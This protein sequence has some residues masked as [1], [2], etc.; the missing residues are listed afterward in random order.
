MNSQTNSLIQF[1]YTH[2]ALRSPQACKAIAY[3]VLNK[4]IL[5]LPEFFLGMAINVVL[6]APSSFLTEW[7]INSCAD[8]LVLLAVFTVALW[9]LSSL[10]YYL[11]SIAWQTLAQKLQHTLRL[12]AY[13]KIQHQRAKEFDKETIGN[14]VAILNDDIN[15]IES[16]FRFAANDSIHL[17]VGTIMI[18]CTYLY[19]SPLIAGIA[20]LPLPLVIFL[21]FKFQKKLQLNYLLTRNQAGKV[22][23]HLTNALQNNAFDE[24]V[25]EQESFAYQQ[26]ALQAART[27]AIVNPVIN[28]IIACGFMITIGVSGYLVL[29]GS[30]S[31]GTFSVITLQTQRLLWP[32]ARTAQIIDA[33]ERTAASALRIKSLIEQ[34]AM[35]DTHHTLTPPK[36]SSRETQR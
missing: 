6:N 2:G 24:T 35:S 11:E 15:Q 14:H 16:F 5:T 21:S 34:S 3:S 22:A 29:I 13:K 10:F 30:L 17:V 8:Q 31:A 26:Q 25:L 4:I 33:Y 1:F 36:A 28:I 32:F 23:T 9:S 20:L 27:N 19:Y 18:G 12:T 7:G